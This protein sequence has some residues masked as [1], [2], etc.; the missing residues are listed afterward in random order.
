MRLRPLRSRDAAWRTGRKQGGDYFLFSA[1]VTNSCSTRTPIYCTA[2]PICKSLSLHQSI[3]L[4]RLSYF[5]EQKLFSRVSAT[6]FI[7]GSEEKRRVMITQDFWE[8]DAN[9]DVKAGPISD[10]YIFSANGSA[11]RAYKAVEMEIIPGKIVTEIRQYFYRWATVTSSLSSIYVGYIFCYGS[12][13]A[14]LLLLKVPLVVMI[15]LT[16]WNL[17]CSREESDKNYAYSVTTRV[18]ERF[19]TKLPCHRLEQTYSLGPLS[20]NTEVVLRTSTSVKNNRT[21]YSDDN[22]YQMMKRTY[23]KF[24]NNTLARVGV[25]RN[26][27]LETF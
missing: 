11:V 16:F 10:N 4:V 22:G 21:L 1:N 14:L 27:F 23:R 7:H 8:Y 15:M 18:P 3:T 5:N 9:G 6:L 25:F 20:L 13:L 2:S 12:Y 17:P 19:G 24:T 26:A